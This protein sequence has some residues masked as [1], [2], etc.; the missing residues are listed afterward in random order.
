[1][2][3]DGAE[4]THCG[5]SLV[6]LSASFLPP[7]TPQAS[8][9][10]VS[11][12]A[13]EISSPGLPASLAAVKESWALLRGKIGVVGQRTLALLFEK[14]PDRLKLFGFQDDTSYLNARSL[15]V[16]GELLMTD[17]WFIIGFGWVK[18]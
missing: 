15:K 16:T 1:M 17:H 3:L 18:S 7:L 4:S 13:P 11:V 12:A 10:G 6:G 8:A 14:H 5:P 9:A 2:T